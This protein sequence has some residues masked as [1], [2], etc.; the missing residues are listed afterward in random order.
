MGIDVRIH[1]IYFQLPLSR[2][3]IFTYSTF[4]DLLTD[5]DISALFNDAF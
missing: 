4:L 1:Q 3:N 5:L 2:E